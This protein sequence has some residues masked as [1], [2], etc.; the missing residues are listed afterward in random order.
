M[1]DEVSETKTK[2]GEVLKLLQ[3]QNSGNRMSRPRSRSPVRCFKCGRNG[4]FQADCRSKIEKN[5]CYE[6]GEQGHFVRDCP[7]GSSSRGNSPVRSGV[8][9]RSPSQSSD[10]SSLN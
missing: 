9:S 2:I 7:K 3:N 1:E 5:S 6:C 8:R 4:H 10:R